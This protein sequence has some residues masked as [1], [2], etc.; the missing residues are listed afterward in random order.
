MTYYKP[1]AIV[2]P[3]ETQFAHL[4]AIQIAKDMNIKTTLALDG[5][6]FLKNTSG[7]FP[8][9]RTYQSTFDYYIA[10]GEYA[11]KLY[12][13]YDYIS[14]KQ[15]L[16]YQSPKVRNIKEREAGASLVIVMAFYPNVTNPDS[17]WDKRY[18]ITLDVVDL[19]VKM[20]EKSILIKV[21]NGFSKDLDA[22]MFTKY[23]KELNYNPEVNIEVVVGEFP[24]IVHKAKMVVGQISTA[25]F[26]SI[27]SNVPYYIYE[28][29]DA[30]KIDLDFDEYHYDTA[31]TIEQLK[32]NIFANND[33]NTYDR[34]FFM[35]GS[36]L[37]NF[38][39]EK[40]PL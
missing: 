6:P 27:V 12:S 38:R 32:D 40:E 23:L 20:G 30:G 28:P 10:F 7:T 8:L 18:S 35:N 3:T 2:F 1:N 25:L 31:R 13:K 11:R 33:G 24:E 39:L 36:D 17:R 14:D 16:V 26:E 9:Y 29:Y 22:F 21:K 5:Y 34:E 15:I 4:I 19:M 37:E